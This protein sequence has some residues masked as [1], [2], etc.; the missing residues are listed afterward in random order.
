MKKIL[1]LLV[2]LLFFSICKNVTFPDSWYKTVETD[3]DFVKEKTEK[4]KKTQLKCY[5]SIDFFIVLML[6]NIP[7]ITS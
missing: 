6:F 1:Q 3:L 5:I 4:I 2:I 7:G